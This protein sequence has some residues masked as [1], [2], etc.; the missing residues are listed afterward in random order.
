MRSLALIAVL[1]VILGTV[2]QA[3][4]EDN[5]EFVQEGGVT[6]RKVRQIVSRP[7][8]EM[9]TEVQQQTTYT[10]KTVH[11]VH[12][13]QVTT[14]VPVTQYRWE[15]YR[16]GWPNPFASRPMAYRLVPHTRWEPR[17][18]TLRIPVTRTE[19]VPQTQTVEVPVRILKFVEEERITKVA[20]TPT[21]PH[22]TGAATGQAIATRPLYG[23]VER[24]D[25]LPGRYGAAIR[26]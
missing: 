25:A 8:A 10:P 14:Y 13:S 23:G 5:S 1:C 16:T 17:V 11:N 20:V 22:G 26:R 7:V 12:E 4:G 21:N 24:L 19:W 2:Q 15:A 9:T 3:I 6:Y 18:A